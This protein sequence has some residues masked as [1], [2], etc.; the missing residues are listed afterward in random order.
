MISERFEA[1]NS[2]FACPQAIAPTSLAAEARSIKG[3]MP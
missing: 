1:L 2:L 3:R